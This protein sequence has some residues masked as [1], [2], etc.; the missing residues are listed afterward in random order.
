M[1]TEPRMTKYLGAPPML[2]RMIYLKFCVAK[3][4]SEC[5]EGQ[6]ADLELFIFEEKPRKPIL[7]CNSCKRKVC[8]DSCGK[9]E[10]TEHIQRG[11]LA[12]DEDGE[13]IMIDISPFYKGSIKELNDEEAYRVKGKIREYKGKLYMTAD[14]VLIGNSE[15]FLVTH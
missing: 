4:I 13:K 1:T 3:K 5:I 14:E 12:M 2:K 10:Y 6:N 15:H 8:Q 7:L 11:Y 9:E